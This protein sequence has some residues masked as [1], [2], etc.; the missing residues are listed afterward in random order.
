MENLK[1]NEST[2][3]SYFID[4]AVPSKG[5]ASSGKRLSRQ[6]HEYSF[7]Q[8]QLCSCASGEEEKFQKEKPK[9]KW[10]QE[11]ESQ[12]DQAERSI[13]HSVIKRT[14]PPL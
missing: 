1:N 2:K 10:E 3:W 6:S 14:V 12:K 4:F 8:I 7:L 5:D 11:L 13:I 9:G